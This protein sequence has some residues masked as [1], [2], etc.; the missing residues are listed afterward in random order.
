VNKKH[1]AS[2]RQLDLGFDSEF[3]S[4]LPRSATEKLLTLT[5]AASALGVPLFAFRRAANA[6]TFPVYR[7][8]NGRARVR[9][10]EVNAAIEKFSRG[11][12]K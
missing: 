3:V 6:A 7:V 10:S 11:P 1:Q 8:G 2:E 9:L 5:S 12:A 4:G